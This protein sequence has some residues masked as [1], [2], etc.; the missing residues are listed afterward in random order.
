MQR[1]RR[2]KC[3]KCLRDAILAFQVKLTYF[4][5]FKGEEISHEN[6]NIP[7]EQERKK[8]F[9]PNFISKKNIALQ[10]PNK[11]QCY[12]LRLCTVGLKDFPFCSELVM[13]KTWHV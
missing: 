5:S 7:R 2:G 12:N 9:P 13:N 3:S 10:L 11:T 1:E 6:K 8:Y 4:F